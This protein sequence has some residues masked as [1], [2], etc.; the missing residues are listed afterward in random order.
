MRAGWML[1]PPRMMR[2]FLRPTICRLPSRVEP[3]EVAAHEPA[4][5][6]EGILGRRLVVEVAEHQQRAARADLADLARLRLAVGILLVPQP[7]LVALARLAARRR[8]RFDVV[9]GQRVLVR[10]VLGHAVDV[11]RLDAEVEE[12]A[13][14][15]GRDDRARHVERLSRLPSCCQAARLH[16]GE[17]VDRV[18]RHA[19]HVGRAGLEDP[20]ERLHARQRGRSPRARSP[21]RGSA[22]S[23]PCRYG[24]KA[25]CGCRA[26]CA[27][28][29]ASRAPSR[30]RWRAACCPNAARLSAC[31]WCRK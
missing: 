26:P 23:R 30:G 22:R 13:R 6:V 18:R 31:R 21:R 1:W 3:A 2:S 7:R 25:D 24:A 8:D 10:A 17:N 29:D 27:R 19:H 4:A 11:L 28:R 20:V 15:L 16:V 9:V 12:G 5:R 14:R